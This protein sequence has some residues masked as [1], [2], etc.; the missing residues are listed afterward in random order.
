MNVLKS[1]AVFCFVGML[2]LISV[3]A[4]KKMSWEEFQATRNDFIIQHAGLNEKESALFLPLYGEMKNKVGRLN[5]I[6][7][8]NERELNK[9]EEKFTEEQYKEALDLINNSRI[10]K[11]NIEKEY[12]EKFRDFL[13][14]EKIYK[15]HMAEIEFHR[16]VL[17]KMIR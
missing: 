12:D 16:K 15:I 11:A 13:T 10:E 2:P 17:K 3:D 4:Q 5:R 14:N 8:H 9:D 1:I 7:S 6:I